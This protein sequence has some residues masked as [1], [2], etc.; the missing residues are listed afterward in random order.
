[1]PHVPTVDI[2]HLGD[3]RFDTQLERALR[4]SPDYDVSQW[5]FVPNQYTEYRYILGTRGQKPLIC[6]GINPSTARPGDLDPT[7]KSVERVAKANGFDSF[8]MFNVYAQRATSPDDMERT[9]NP[10]LHR[11]NMRAFAYAL[12]LNPRPV[13]WAAWGTII[14]K[15]PYL[16][17]CLEDM[18]ALGR[19]YGAQWVTCGRRSKAGHPHHPLY[20]FFPQALW[21][22]CVGRLAFPIFAFQVAEGWYRTHDR[23]RYFLRLALCGLLSE[24]PFDLAISGQPI[25]PGYQNVLWTFCIAAAALWAMEALQ[26]RLQIPLPLAALCAGAAGY[27]LGEALQSD[28][29]GPG[30]LTVLVFALCR[31]WHIGRLPELAAMLV[32]NG[33]LL[34]SA[35]MTLW[36]VTLPVELLATAALLPIWL[37]RGRQGPHSPALQGIWYAFYPAHLLLLWWLARSIGI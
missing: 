20:L 24:I 25:D 7:L 4:P 23:R 29:F 27:L 2:R 5:L 33:W 8:I 26:R 35:D 31:Q 14:E 34:P 30:V 3:I 6:I 13:V 37:Y 22:R 19:E 28:Y 16:W 32:I 17:T 18:I 15:R 21:M 10:E 9:C 1:M 12:S 11:E 36:G